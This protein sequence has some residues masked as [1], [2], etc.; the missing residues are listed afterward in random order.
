MTWF[1][2]RESTSSLFLTYFYG[3]SQKLYLSD[4][5]DFSL[6]VFQSNAT[7]SEVQLKQ[8]QNSNSHIKLSMGIGFALS[9][10]WILMNHFL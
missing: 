3:V 7:S 9:A 1:P 10:D 2:L 6:N 8:L 5:N 4:I